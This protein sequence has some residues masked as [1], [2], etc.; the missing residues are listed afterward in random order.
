MLNRE[1]MDR[2]RSEEQHTEYLFVLVLN[3]LMSV[4]LFFLHPVFGVLGVV[5]TGVCVYLV[6]MSGKENESRIKNAIENLNEDFDEVTKNAVFGM[7]FPMAVLNGEGNFLWYN[8]N[9]KKL[10]Y[11]EQ[12][13][14]G[15]NYREFFPNVGLKTLREKAGEPFRIEQD[16]SAYLFYHNSTESEG[17]EPLIL[18]Y[19][20]DNTENEA[21]RQAWFDQQPVVGTI[22]LDNYDDVRSKTAEADRPILFAEIDRELNACVARYGAFLLKYEMDRYL[23]LMERAMFE[24]AQKEKFRLFDPIRDVR[25]GNEMTP[26]LSVGFAQGERTPEELLR[27]S[28]S[29]VDIALSRGGDQIVIKDGE[30]LSFFGG[31]TQATERHTK[32]K[33]RVTAH[34]IGQMIREASEVFVMG[35]ANPDMD[36]FGSCLG[37]LCLVQTYDATVHIVLDEVTPA[38]DNLYNKA[39]SELPGLGSLI[40]SPQEAAEQVQPTSL[41]IVLDNHRHY[42]TAAPALLDVGARVVVVDHHRRG[43]DAIAHAAIS[44]IEPYA[45]SASELVTELLTY[46]DENIKL[47]VVVAEGLLAGIT[48]DTKNFFYQ[49][50]VRTFEAAALLKR[51]GA[52]SVEVK[53]LFKDEFELIRC[54]S[55]VISGATE[56]AHH[57]IIGRF[58]REREGSTLIASQAAD[59]LLNIRGID[60]SFVLTRI[61]GK[62]HISARSLGDVSVQLIMERIGGGGHL[63][64]AATQLAMP[65]DL[66]EQQL[67]KAILEYFEEEQRDEGHSD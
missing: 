57:T 13:R 21:V 4:A 39:V 55:E 66:A 44:Y 65:I 35:H 2:N 36:S 3:A 28:R 26:T 50:G 17:R 63:T 19:G 46:T 18:L 6:W 67:K 9:F 59:D 45:S 37:M 1:K 8:S 62:S 30:N 32:V 33:A 60:A 58:E 48:V 49:T 42:S 47:P 24:K 31:K 15:K 14:L 52:N 23:M 29:A 27:D 56:F 10:F 64:A 61:N 7:P 41:V 12:T 34:A 20:I 25:R 40:L 16:Q 5:A 51:H 43:R 53:Q 22:Y 38:I 54:R 11:I